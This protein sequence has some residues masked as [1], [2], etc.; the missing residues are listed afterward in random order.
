MNPD[1]CIIGAGISGLGVAHFLRRKGLHVM[2]LERSA[3]AG[4]VIRTRRLR[5]FLFD[6]GPNSTL[7]A[8]AA[9]KQIIAD[10]NLRD[11]MVTAGTHAGNRYVWRRGKLRL[12]PM[13][14]G[15]LVQTD[16]LTWRGKI[17]LLAE[18][19]I[20]P[21]KD[22]GDESVAQ[23]VR[24]RL[25]QEFLDYL[26][27]PFV[28]GVYAG[29][30]S[31]L[32]IRAAF[33]RVYD[34]EQQHGGLIRGFVAK[35][36]AAKRTGQPDRTRA[37]LI[38]F[39]AGMQVLTDALAR[40]LGT[41]LVL[42]TE[43]Q[44]LVAEKEGFRILASTPAGERVAIHSRQVVLATPARQSARLLRRLSPAASRALEEIPYAPV[45]V[46]FMGYPEH[47]PRR[48][49]NG[50]GFLV[51]AVER[52]QILGCI[53]SSS[54]FPHRAPDGFVALTTF[55]GGTRQ[56]E[57][58]ALE[59]KPLSSLV[60]KELA[61]LMG[62]SGSPEFTAVKK[63]KQAIPQYD[64]QHESRLRA[65]EAAEQA[66][67]GLHVAGNFRRGIS[68][69]DCLDQAAELAERIAATC[70]AREHLTLS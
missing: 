37:G 23:F 21:K 66:I 69:A 52:R 41:A 12:V 17:R 8:S 14:P 6:Q 44:E 56:P 25:G 13:G 70:E 7:N 39:D 2:V 31:Q 58:A 18:P 40:S 29:D 61:E 51:P 10:L 57:L 54:L 47:A 50:F 27:N 55:V 67:P 62:L 19:L 15:A 32:S 35:R 38:S 11:R 45:A 46:V 34:L 64:L 3:R 24:R 49:L 59:E 28:A 42:Q 43:V 1:V 68:V 65:I 60:Q 22:G 53:W 20:P 30:P 5:G 48:S 63:W 9:L 36:K 33:R 16:L 26:I 4:G